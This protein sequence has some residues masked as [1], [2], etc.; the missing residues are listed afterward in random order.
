[1][2][3]NVKENPE[4]ENQQEAAIGYQS[5]VMLIAG[6][7]GLLFVPIFKT[8]THLPPYM[9]MMFSLGIVWLISEYLHPNENFTKS[10][11]IPT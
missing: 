8:I 7:S 3:G 9:G 1:M 10:L 4:S 11:N 6:L 5:V 2:K